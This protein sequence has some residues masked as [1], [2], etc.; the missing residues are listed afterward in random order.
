[1]LTAAITAGLAAILSLF[2]IKPGAY[3]AV[4]AVVVKILLVF[5]GLF[6]GAR[7]SKKR[8][9]VQAQE[10]AAAAPPEPKP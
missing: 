7:I 1:V 9:A 4:V 2:G 10:D 6:I 3:L 8:R 5:S